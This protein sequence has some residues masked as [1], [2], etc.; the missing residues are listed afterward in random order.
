MAIAD[1]DLALEKVREFLGLLDEDEQAL[2]SG[3]TPPSR[4]ERVLL[5]PLIEKIAR[6]IDGSPRFRSE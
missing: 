6:E 2:K 1:R 5:Q 3:D 4:E